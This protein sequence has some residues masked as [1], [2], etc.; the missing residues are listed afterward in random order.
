M[1]HHQAKYGTTYQ[2][3]KS[4]FVIQ[5]GLIYIYLKA[6]AYPFSLFAGFWCTSHPAS[7]QQ[8]MLVFYLLACLLLLLV[9]LAWCKNFIAAPH[10]TAGSVQDSATKWG[11]SLS[12]WLSFLLSWIWL[13]LRLLKQK[14]FSVMLQVLYKRTECLSVWQSNAF[15]IIVLTSSN[16]NCD[17]VLEDSTC[18][19]VIY[20]HIL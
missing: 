15:V 12:F 19:L 9:L 17:L 1:T 5:N 10:I 18:H 2:R 16:L 20:I 3:S 11:D 8:A 6:P 4:L 7:P 13:F 14:Y